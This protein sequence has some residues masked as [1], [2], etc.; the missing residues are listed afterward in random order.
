M[1]SIYDKVGVGYS[2]TRL[3]DPRIADRIIQALG[4]SARV[5][6]VGAGA[7]S[8]EPRDRMVVAVEPSATM[9]RQRPVGSAPVIRGVAESLPLADG[10]VDAAL[11]ILTVHHWTDPGRGFVEMRRVAQIRVVILTWDQDVWESF[12][13]IREYLPCIRDLDRRRALAIADIVSAFGGSQILRVPIPHDCIDGFHGAFWRR[14]EAYLDPR[15]RSGISTYAVMSPD[16]R[17]EGL[18]RLAA[19]IQSGDWE[20]RH[21]DLLDLDEVD[22][23]YRL[24]VAAA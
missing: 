9:I 19:D 6:N 14:P 1:A 15:V 5:V 13:L 17:D 12:W 16:E 2:V 18:Q 21:R 20:D 22:L 11:A 10:A 8:Y 7:G 23:G 3:R 24:I 4:D